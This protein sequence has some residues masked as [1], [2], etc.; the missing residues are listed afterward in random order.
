MISIPNYL[1]S[2]V[3]RYYN[4]KEERR[5]YKSMTI[6]IKMEFSPKIAANMA[7]V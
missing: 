3:N 5:S 6:L 4:S 1:K 7:I 2:A